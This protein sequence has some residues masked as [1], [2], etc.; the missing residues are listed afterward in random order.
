MPGRYQ[1]SSAGTLASDTGWLEKAAVTEKVYQRYGN[2]VTDI[3][4]H[5]GEPPLHVRPAAE[6]DRVMAYFMGQLFQEGASSNHDNYLMAAWAAL[7]PDYGRYGNLKL[8]HTHRTLAGWRKERPMHS[9]A[10]HAFPVIAGLM[11]RMAQKF[12]VMAGL[13][14]ATTY[15]VYGRPSETLAL[16][17]EDLIPPIGGGRF[18]SVLLRSQE[19]EVPTKTGEY[20]DTVVWDVKG[21]EFMEAVFGR[22]RNEKKLGKIWTWDY[23]TLL[24]M[25][26]SCAVDLQVEGLVPYSLR[27]SAASHDALH[28]LRSLQEIQKRGRWRA[29]RS[30]TR[31]EKS[32]R[33]GLGYLRLKAPIREYLEQCAANLVSWLR[34]PERGRLPPRA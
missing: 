31:Y 33:V 10:P 13:W 6:V 23:L 19:L 1:T 20:D 24:S 27:H 8:P 22:L 7:F 18:W 4:K 17:G 26:K 25:V 2:F 32:G 28:K 11:V 3:L 16:R 15:G 12:G 30:V 14:V 5:A 9:R 34:Q 21:L 29:H